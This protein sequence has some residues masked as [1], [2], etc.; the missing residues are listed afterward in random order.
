MRV[1]QRRF[2]YPYKATLAICSDVDGMAAARFKRIHRFLNTR[3]K[4]IP[5]Y[6]DGLGLDIGDSFFLRTFPITV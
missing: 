2:P 3:T 6:G 4:N 5:H 1:T